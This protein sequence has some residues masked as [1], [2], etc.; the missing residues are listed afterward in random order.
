MVG[1]GSMI[2]N[3][4]MSKEAYQAK[5]QEFLKQYEEEAE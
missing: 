3:A 2:D 4:K 1:Q 5:V